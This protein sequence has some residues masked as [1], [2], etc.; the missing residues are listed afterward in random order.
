MGWWKW[1]AG[2]AAFAA[3]AFSAAV[4]WTIYRLDV[5][6]VTDDLHVIYGAGGN[7]GVLRTGEGTVI[8]DTM[9]L[10][11]QGKR[12]RETAEALTGEPVVM[13][14]NTHY[15]LDH[16][17]GN[18]GFEPGTRVV[19]TTRTREHLETFDA[20]FWEGDAAQLLPNETFDEERRLQVGSKTLTLL[21]PGRGHTDGDLVVLFEE[22]RVAHMGDLFF[23]R[24][25]PNIDLEA[26]GSVVR[27]PGTIDSA[28][29]LPFDIII[30]GHGPVSGKERLREF[31]AFLAQLARI[32]ERAVDGGVPVDEFVLTDELTTDREFTEIRMLVPLGLD[33]PFVLRRAWEE[34][35][36]LKSAQGP[37]T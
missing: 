6:Q 5:E 22:E 16:T 26:G 1:L 31:R 12:I 8:V 17:H 3:I 34:A 11:W 32:A 35:S 9:T 37:G 25:Y 33:R 20:D 13:I 15:H 36:A 2:I 21:W 19:S 28:L 10:A 30:P 14:I 7:V 29:T 4:F 27:W 24:H 18:P 23:N